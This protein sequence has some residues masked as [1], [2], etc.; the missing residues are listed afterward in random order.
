VS[1]AG[2][3]RVSA[4]SCRGVVES[5]AAICHFTDSYYHG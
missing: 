1:N 5:L 4:T 2:Y 3:T